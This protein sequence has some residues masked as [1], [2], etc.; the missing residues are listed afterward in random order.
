[1]LPVHHAANLAFIQTDTCIGCMLCVP[2]CPT[3]AI[4]GEAKHAHKVIN[5]KCTGCG[6]CVP[7]CPVDCITM[8]PQYKA[9]NATPASALPQTLKEKIAAAR[10]SAKIRHSH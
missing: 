2:V 1:M 6:L 5:E 8:V 7:V 4:E 10:A 9:Q 3:L